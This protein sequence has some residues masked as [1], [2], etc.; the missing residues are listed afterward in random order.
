[1]LTHS[2]FF[3]SLAIPSPA[4]PTAVQPK[5]RHSNPRAKPDLAA[6][7]TR[8]LPFVPPPNPGSATEK[9]EEEEEERMCNF[10]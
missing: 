3:S 2:L 10:F 9:N 7:S 1:M 4:H 6:A 5:P 8:T